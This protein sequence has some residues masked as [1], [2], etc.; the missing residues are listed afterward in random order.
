M[1]M[2]GPATLPAPVGASDDLTLEHQVQID[3]VLTRVDS[4]ERNARRRALIATLIP[5]AIGGLV[6]AFLLWQITLRTQQL[7]TLD[8]QTA[9]LQ[10][11][12]IRAREDL[13][14]TTEQLT[15]A[16]SDAAA[17]RDAL[18][19]VQR[20]LAN[21]RRELDNIKA[22]L[23]NAR[24][25]RDQAL[26]DRDAAQAQVR[27]LEA[28]LEQLRKDLDETTEQL[29]LATDFDRYRFTGD[30]SLMIKG[31]ASRSP[32]VF[33]LLE[34]LQALEDASW[35]LGGRSPKSGFDSPGF[36]AYV[37][38]QNDL[39]Y[40]RKAVDVDSS[41]RLRGI[42]TPRDPAR[43]QSGDVAFYEAGYTMFYFLDDAGQPFV[44]GMTPL[45]V[46]G[47][48][49]DFAPLLGYGVPGR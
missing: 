34:T 2:N 40:G 6:L 22:E 39:L 46:M 5:I 19:Q 47:L 32:E 27:E 10:A 14:T 15:L 24:A 25:E 37:L 41:N 16:Q 17:T 31:L 33:G 4:Y 28:Q 11:T 1:T 29:K 23:A 9:D 42:L 18:A 26:R 30:I 43:P 21:A 48:R 12:L 20:D 8:Q 45:G 38:E 3:A 44:Y 36:A 35:S 49:P 7:S 13:N